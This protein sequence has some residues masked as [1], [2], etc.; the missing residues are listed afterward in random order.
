LARL[1]CNAEVRRSLGQSS[2]RS[3]LDV[4]TA[5]LDRLRHY[6]LTYKQAPGAAA[7][8][9][10]ITHVYGRE[11]AWDVISRSLADYQEQFG[12]LESILTEALHT[13]IHRLGEAS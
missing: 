4:S 8:T 13:M 12:A 11:E 2:T 10:T 3:I 7:G 9:S 6:F 5:T 1:F